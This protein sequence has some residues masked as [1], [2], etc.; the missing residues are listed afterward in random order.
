MDANAEW[1][2][3]ILLT[4]SFPMHPFSTVRFSD[5]FKGQRM[6]ALGTNGLIVNVLLQKLF[7][8]PMF[9]MMQKATKSFTS[10]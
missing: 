6:G 10:V 2:V 7:T 1:K 4:H 5:V 8:E 9:L 3:D